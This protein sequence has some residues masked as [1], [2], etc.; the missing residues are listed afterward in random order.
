MGDAQIGGVA[1]R[2]R[3]EARAPEIMEA[4][5][6]LIEEHGAAATSMARIAQA[7]GVSEA[8][9]YKYFESKQDLVN[10]V[11]HEWA[12]PFIDRLR[13]E[14]EHVTGLQPRL[15]LIAIRFLRSLGETPKLH[16][17]F[18]QELRW[19]NYRGT[20]LHK[21]NQSFAGTVITVVE[22]AIRSGEVRADVDPVMVRDMLFG[23]LEHIGMRTSF[24]GRDIDY[25]STAA[26][27]VA[28]V[29]NGIVTRSGGTSMPDELTRLSALID[30]LEG[31]TGPR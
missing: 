22:D 26:R 5:R 25:E 19:T 12:T 31:A 29:L 24:V 23:G 9:V 7:A 27:Y 18:F 4:A 6:R 20:P 14:L 10:Q 16:R 28:T 2:R 3:K 8:T 1:W 11:L 15:T 21:A 17:V 30:R 13:S